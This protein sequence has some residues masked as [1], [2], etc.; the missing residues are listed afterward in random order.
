V[1]YSA[2]RPYFRLLGT[3]LS[4][5]VCTRCHVLV[6]FPECAW[7]SRILEAM[8]HPFPDHPVRDRLRYVCSITSILQYTTLIRPGFVYFASWDY[9][10]STYAPSLPH[11]GT[12]A[13]EPFAAIA[14]DVILSSYL[15]LFISFY[16]ATY[17]KMSNRRSTARTAQ[18]AE[19]RMEKAE[20]PTMMETAGTATQAVKAATNGMHNIS[21]SGTFF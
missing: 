14:G 2:H 5:L 19:K 1:L 12:C 16:I 3:H 4:E 8:D 11:V 17:R 9:F 21:P 18:K 7:C 15:V 6:L 10:T 13:G 20:V